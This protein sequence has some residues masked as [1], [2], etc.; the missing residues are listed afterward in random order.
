M[1]S[2]WSNF[3]SISDSLPLRSMVFGTAGWMPD[4]NWPDQSEASMV[5]QVHLV[6][7]SP[8]SYQES[9]ALPFFHH[10]M[11]L[12]EQKSAKQLNKHL[13]EL[14]IANGPLEI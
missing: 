11:H 6:A 12:P 1:A 10:G 5:L 8:W 14:K 7:F 2:C 9:A 4:G 3:S 13:E